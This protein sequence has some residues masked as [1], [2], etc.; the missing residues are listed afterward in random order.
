M[1]LSYVRDG[2][3]D[4]DC[5]SPDPDLLDLPDFFVLYVRFSMTI[6]GIKR[7][8]FSYLLYIFFFMYLSNFFVGLMYRICLNLP[9]GQIVMNTPWT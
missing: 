1:G 8:D 9:P 7:K 4:L 2:A 6:F 3:Y 5:F